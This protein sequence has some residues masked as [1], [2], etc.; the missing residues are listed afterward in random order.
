MTTLEQ[1]EKRWKFLNELHNRGVESVKFQLERNADE[2]LLIKIE[3][4]L[5][6]R[7]RERDSKINTLL[8]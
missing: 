6:K 3:L 5:E 8:K 2:I 4:E 1:K 7:M